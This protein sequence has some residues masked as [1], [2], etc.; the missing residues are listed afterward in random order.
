M[1]VM[2][3]QLRSPMAPSPQ[4][5]R[6]RTRG[7]RAFALRLDARRSYDPRVHGMRCLPYVDDFLAVVRTREEALLARARASE[8]MERLG[9]VRHPEGGNVIRYSRYGCFVKLRGV[10]HFDP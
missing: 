6:R 1:R 7:Q 9:I 2:V 5:A 3:R 8:V 10:E 4:V